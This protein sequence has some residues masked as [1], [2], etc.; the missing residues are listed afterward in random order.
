MTDV[1]EDMEHLLERAIRC[2]TYVLNNLLY[3]IHLNKHRPLNRRTLV[4]WMAAFMPAPRDPRVVLQRQLSEV[5]SHAGLR[6]WGSCGSLNSVFSAASLQHLV[7]ED[8]G[9]NLVRFRVNNSDD[10]EC[11]PVAFEDTHFTPVPDIA[12]RFTS[13]P[14]FDQFECSSATSSDQQGGKLAEMEA[15]LASLR[16]QLALLVMA[17]E[18]SIVSEKM[19][20]DDCVEEESCTLSASHAAAMPLPGSPALCSTLNDSGCESSEGVPVGQKAS[21]CAVYSSSSTSNHNILVRAPPAPPPPP[22]PPPLPLLP[23]SSNRETVTELIRKRKALGTSYLQNK[24]NVPDMADVLK[25]LGSVKLRAVERSPGG[26]PMSRRRVDRTPTDP[27]SIIACALKKK[28]AS[29]RG[30]SPESD[31][32]NDMSSFLSDKSA[33]PF[34]QH[35][36]RKTQRR[37]SLLNDSEDWTPVQ[38]PLKTLNV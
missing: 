18:S 14:N 3:R 5:P 27:A 34:G 25:G 33:S 8:L 21:H 1:F 6:S 4:R 36:L 17:Q 15:E 13:T 28:F 22:P 11:S 10:D 38:S 19:G 16:K 37:L 12:N 20:G 35:L 30:L 26:T 29:H 9:D 7:E 2:L 31:Q 23:A 32:E 24:G